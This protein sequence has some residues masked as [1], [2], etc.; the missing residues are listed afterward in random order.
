MGRPV[1]R[2]DDMHA[3]ADRTTPGVKMIRDLCGDELAEQ[4]VTRTPALVDRIDKLLAAEKDK[5]LLASHLNISIRIT[6]ENR[7]EIDRLKSMV[8]RMRGGSSNPA[9]II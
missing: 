3:Y 1:A 6:E 5:D 7:K 4:I 2:E 8:D 9:S